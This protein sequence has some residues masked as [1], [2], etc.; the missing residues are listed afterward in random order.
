MVDS[1]NS[2][3]EPFD[4]SVVAHVGLV[5]HIGAATLSGQYDLDD[6]TQDV[7]ACVFAKRDQLRDLSRLR[8]W[9][10][11][12]ARNTAQNWNRKQRVVFTELSDALSLPAL[13]ADEWLSERERWSA[14]VDALSRLPESD[15]ALIRAYYY[16]ELSARELQARTRLSAGAIRVR[17]S[18]ARAVLRERLTPLLCV[19]GVVDSAQTP[20]RFG[21]VSKGSN[22]MGV[23][24]SLACSLAVAGWL[25]VGVYRVEEAVWHAASLSPQGD[26][27][28]SVEILAADF[29]PPVE[30]VAAGG[31]APASSPISATDEKEPSMGE[32]IDVAPTRTVSTIVGT[33]HAMLRKVES[34]AW[35]MDQLYGV[36]GHAF[37]FEM[38]E[39]GEDVWQEAQLDYG[40][41]SGFFEM[42]PHLGYR[43]TIFEAAPNDEGIDFQAIIAD[44]WDAVRASVDR[45]IPALVWQPMTLKMKDEG[46]RAGAWG[47]LIGY[48]KSDET[49]AVRHQYIGRGKETYPVRYDA[50]G[51]VASANWFC[52]LV[53]DGP[54]ESFNAADTHLNALQNA[55]AFARNTRWP[56]VTGH[57]RGDARGLAAYDLWRE[58]LESGDA[59]PEYSQYHAHDLQVF[60]GH[61]AVYL[62]DLADMFPTAAPDLHAAAVQYDQL[63]EASTTLH[64]LCAEAKDAGGFSDDTRAEAARLVTAAQKSDRA[65]IAS[66]EA[67]LVVLDEAR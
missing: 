26:L 60:R 53:F 29:R 22:R 14:L 4:R 64:D 27:L 56:P 52:V 45:G 46:I 61:A 31:E 50:L 5:R 36:L 47:M 49:Y 59:V 32:E 18:R 66:I 51:T 57:H 1:S 35:S 10:A 21:E 58:A 65:A 54:E 44:A 67:A 34:S 62:R 20:R 13:P 12:I 8:S 28:E 41:G 15:Q 39:G 3:A 25:G 55:V 6:F 2:Q 40:R 63:V 23:A 19:L 11:S 43:M 37:T 48:D 17:L 7:L 24:G 38:K 33:L 30:L 9:M 42:L 16:D